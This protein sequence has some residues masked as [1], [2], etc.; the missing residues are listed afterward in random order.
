MQKI[1]ISLLV[2]FIFFFSAE[3][4][5]QVKLVSWNIQ[6]FGKSKDA[7]EMAF[8]AETLKGFDV[9]AIQE[10]VSGYGGAQAVANLADELNRK[11]AKWYYAISNPTISSPYSTERY[12]FL[13]KTSK[14]KIIGKAWLDQNF[15]PE[16]EREPFMAD[17][18]YKGKTFTVVSFHAIPKSKNPE[19]EIKYFKFFPELYP[20]KNLIFLG[21]FNTPQSN[22]V[23]N[24]LKEMDYEPA[25]ENQKTSLRTKCIEADCLASKYDNIFFSLEKIDCIKSGIEPFFLHFSEIKKAREVSDHVPVWMEFFPK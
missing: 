3:V 2:L 10:V 1:K 12:A 4:F 24:P 14:V 22:N 20:N 13:W 6:N 25:F 9:V 23:F 16:I 17:F 21:D 5:A 11:G 8:I 7:E 19:Q 18:Q 15:V